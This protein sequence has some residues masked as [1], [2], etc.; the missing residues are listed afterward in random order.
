MLSKIQVAYFPS[1]LFSAMTQYDLHDKINNHKEIK[2]GSFL[3]VMKSYYQTYNS[4]AEKESYNIIG[5]V[6]DQ[7]V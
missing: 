2:N 3:K 1:I 7:L 4:N 5:S 6:F